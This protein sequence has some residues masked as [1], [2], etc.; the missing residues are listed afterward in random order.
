MDFVDVVRL[1]VNKHNKH[2]Y[3][4]KYKDCLLSIVVNTSGP[5]YFTKTPDHPSIHIDTITCSTLGTGNGKKLL[6][7]AITCCELFQVGIWTGE[8]Q[9]EKIKT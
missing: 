3:E 9:K 5:P 1:Q 7:S 4:F 8:P 2:Q 6:C